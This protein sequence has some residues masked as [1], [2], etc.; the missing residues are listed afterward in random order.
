M[1]PTPP[2]S[3]HKPWPAIAE[4]LVAWLAETDVS[5]ITAS[6][7]KVRSACGIILHVDHNPPMRRTPDVLPRESRDASRDRARP[8]GWT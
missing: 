3:R 7:R 4:R 8:E 5:Y 6:P 1:L 2:R